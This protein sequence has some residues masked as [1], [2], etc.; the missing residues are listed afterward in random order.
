MKKTDRYLR[1]NQ[2]IGQPQ[3]TP[4]QAAI[5]RKIG[6]SPRR[7]QEKIDPIIPVSS[8]SWWAGIKT[9]RFPQSIKLGPKT[10]VWKESE[11]LE[12]SSNLEVA[13]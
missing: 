13:V 1:L 11:V 9:G 3:I 7:P 4:E 2:I 10:T 12:I 8:S 6:K 5:N